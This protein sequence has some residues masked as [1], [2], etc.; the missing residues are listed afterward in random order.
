MKKAIT[1]PEILSTISKIVTLMYTSNQFL[2]PDPAFNKYEDG[3]SLG[4]LGFKEGN[5]EE[6]DDDVS[7]L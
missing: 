4:N 7:L 3:E 1:E 6:G 2:L 5:L